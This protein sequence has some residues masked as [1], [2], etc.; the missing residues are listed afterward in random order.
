MD[1]ATE[2]VEVLGSDISKAILRTPLDPR[3][4][5]PAA[6][7][8]EDTCHARTDS[9]EEMRIIGYGGRLWNHIRADWKNRRDEESS[10]S[11]P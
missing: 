4:T 2:E 7:F 9:S 8:A 10:P 3:R 1:P 6:L 5:I 11:R